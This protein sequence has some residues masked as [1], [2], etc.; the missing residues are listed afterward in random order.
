VAEEFTYICTGKSADGEDIFVGATPERFERSCSPLTGREIIVL[1]FDRSTCIWLIGQLINEL[2]T[3]DMENS[4]GE[5]KD[6]RSVSEKISE[7]I[8]DTFEELWRETE[9]GM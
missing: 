7:E 1:P 3:Y 9:Q 8:T 4:D 5:S 2:V 6:E